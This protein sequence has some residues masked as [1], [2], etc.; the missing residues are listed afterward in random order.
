[1]NPAELEAYQK[2]RRMTIE[3]DMSFAEEIRK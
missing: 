3:S 2:R 1:M